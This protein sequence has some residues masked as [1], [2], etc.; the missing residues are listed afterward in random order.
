MSHYAPFP[1]MNIVTGKSHFARTCSKMRLKQAQSKRVAH[2]AVR[3][4]FGAL[5]LDLGAVSALAADP[6]LTIYNQN[7]AVVRDS[8]RLDLKPGT[9]HVR[10]ADATTYL[11][12]SSVVLRDPAGTHSFTVLEQNFRGD[13]VSQELLL[14]LNEGKTISF[15]VVDQ[16]AGST[17]RKLVSGKVIRAS[18]PIIETDGNLRFSLPGQPLFPSLADDT[19]LKPT[20]VWVVQSEDKASFDAEL[21]Y[22]TGEMVWESDYNLVLPERGDDLD[23]VGWVTMDNHSG[24]TFEHARIKLMAGDVTR[25]QNQAM[26]RARFMG[27]AGGGGGMQP[28]VTEKSFDEYHL[29]TLEHP[30]TLHDNEKKQVEFVRASQVHSVPIYVYDGLADDPDEAQLRDWTPRQVLTEPGYGIKS[31]RK[32]WVMREFTNS[33]ANHLGLPLPKGRVR[34]YRGNADGQMEFTGENTIRHTPRDEVIRL[35]TGSAFDLV[36]ERKQ[37]DF[38]IRLSRFQT[39][40]D[41]TTGLPVVGTVSAAPSGDPPPFINESFEITLRNHKREPV[42]IRVVEHLYRW[43][44]WEIRKQSDPS[45]RMDSQTIEF[46]V[47]VNPDQERKLSYMVHYTWTE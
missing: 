23:L 4:F 31:N 12:P 36:A 27:G 41:P 20:L 13:P 8:V 28:P 14:L 10:F 39:T 32:V 34:V 7:F 38:E 30:T 11:E 16:A 46:R 47:Q 17:T 19:V 1:T 3:C 42:E 26:G 45:A 22:V 40:I 9:N 6:S 24:K 43:V 5:I 18:P 37:T 2:F 33:A 35:A 29:Y 44:N 25:I 21:S 15:E